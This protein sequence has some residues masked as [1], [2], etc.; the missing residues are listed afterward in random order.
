MK[1]VEFPVY[2]IMLNHDFFG[3]TDFSDCY[4]DFD[5]IRSNCG[6]KCLDNQ[7]IVSETLG[8]DGSGLRDLA[9]DFLSWITLVNKGV[10]DVVPMRVSQTYLIVSDWK[11]HLQS[12]GFP[13]VR[14]IEGEII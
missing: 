9:V 14:Y 11:F 3:E 6:M 2:T 10:L 4:S 1:L 8:F 12:S 7:W 5:G 13:L